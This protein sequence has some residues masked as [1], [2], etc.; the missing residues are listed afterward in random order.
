MLGANQ[1]SPRVEIVVVEGQLAGGHV[2]QITV[3]RRDDN[4]RELRSTKDAIILFFGI[5]SELLKAN[6]DGQAL[7][8]VKRDLV[9]VKRDPGVGYCHSGPRGS[10]PRNL[11]SRPR[12]PLPTN[13]RV[14]GFQLSPCG[15]SHGLRGNCGAFDLSLWL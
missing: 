5:F 6:A 15:G 10:V 3:F 8:S 13:L 7:V 4:G 2:G 11:V 12:A 14:L 1:P 9:S